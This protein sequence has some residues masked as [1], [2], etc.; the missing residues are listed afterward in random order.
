MKSTVGE[1]FI[2]FVMSGVAALLAAVVG[3]VGAIFLCEK[4]FSGEMTEWAL[5]LAPA[6]ALVFA[7]TVFV[8]AFRKISTYGESPDKRP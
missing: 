3:F 4:L 1:S 2:A 5:I 7:A 8:F 6:T